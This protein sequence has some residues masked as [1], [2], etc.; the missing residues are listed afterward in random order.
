MKRILIT[1]AHSYIGCSVKAYLERWQ[2][3]YQ[4]DTISLTDGA[5]RECSFR[6][7]DAVLHAAGIAH[8]AKSKEDPAQAELY[9]RVNHRLAVETAQKAKGE[10]VRQFIFLSTESVYGLSAPVGKVV[11]ITRDTPVRPVDN[12]GISKAKAEEGLAQLRSDSFAVAILRPPMIYGKGCKGNYQTMAKLA[13]K[14]PVFPLVENQRSMLYVDNLSEF[15]RL[16]VEDEADGLFCPQNA[17]Y[18]STSD[19]VN[20]IAHANGRGMLMV[21]GFGW[22]L[23]LLSPMTGMVDKAFGS[24]CYDRSLSDYPKDYCITDFAQSIMETECGKE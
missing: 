21:R 16:I 18:V 6:G 7:Y 13:R 11:T 17:E 12:Y 19:M 1:G 2:D 3:S 15:V 23:K 9:D 22:A 20:R 4:V 8:Q 10:G 5:W 14:L 24:L